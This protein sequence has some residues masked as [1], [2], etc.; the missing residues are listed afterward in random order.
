VRFWGRRWRSAN[1]DPVAGA[2]RHAHSERRTPDRAP[3]VAIGHAATHPRADSVAHTESTDYLPAGVGAGRG[4]SVGVEG[5]HGYSSLPLGVCNRDPT[6]HSDDGDNDSHGDRD[7]HDHRDG[8]THDL[9]HAQGLG[10]AQRHAHGHAHC[11]VA[12]LGDGHHLVAVAAA[13]HRGWRRR[14][15]VVGETTPFGRA[16]ADLTT[17]QRQ[18]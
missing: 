15:L 14:R 11:R 13:C 12:D 17:G 1:A 10:H 2:E 8:D 7:H 9:G 16:R 4:V 18:G 3:I 5:T 6:G